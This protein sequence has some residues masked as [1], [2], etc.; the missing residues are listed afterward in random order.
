LH[1]A[2]PNVTNLPPIICNVSI[3]L[4]HK[5]IRFHYKVNIIIIITIIIKLL[6]T[7]V[8][9]Q[10]PSIHQQIGTNIYAESND[11]E[12]VIKKQNDAG[13]VTN[14]STALTTQLQ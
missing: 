4:A 3:A 5:S 6:F 2:C 8:L 12:T 10:Q 14:T 9:S 11:K 13:Y 1:F 7:E